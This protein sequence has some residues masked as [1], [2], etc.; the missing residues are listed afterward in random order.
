MQVIRMTDD[1]AIATAINAALTTFRTAI[2]GLD[3][4]EGKV[5]TNIINAVSFLK[6]DGMPVITAPD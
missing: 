5:L 4:V 6:D 2:T 3:G 1:A